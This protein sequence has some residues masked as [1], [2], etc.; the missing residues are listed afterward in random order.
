MGVLSVLPFINPMVRPKWL[1]LG[2]S[3]SL[4]AAH[5]S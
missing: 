5:A 2:L 3:H 4:P 1:P